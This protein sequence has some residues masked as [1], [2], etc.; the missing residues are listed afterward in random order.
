MTCETVPCL[1]SEVGLV[2]DRECCE[3][4]L[5]WQKINP[6]KAHAFRGPKKARGAATPEGFHHASGCVGGSLT[7]WGV[8]GC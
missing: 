4:G 3:C 5:R 6:V 1:W 7:W 8:A 2:M